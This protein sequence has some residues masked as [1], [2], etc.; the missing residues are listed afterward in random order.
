MTQT[1]EHYPAPPVEEAIPP[2][3]RVLLHLIEERG[4]EADLLFS[5]GNVV[6]RK[7]R[8]VEALRLYRAALLKDA[9]SAKL[10]TNI[11]IVLESLG[12]L[13]EAEQ[14]Y[15]EALIQ[16]A[17]LELALRNLAQ[18][19]ES[20]NDFESA[21]KLVE[22]SQHL[23]SSARVSELAGRAADGIGETDKARRYF[24][25]AASLGS[26]YGLKWLAADDTRQALR[27]LDEE[28]PSSLIEVGRKLHAAYERSPDI[29]VR[30]QRVQELLRLLSEKKLQYSADSYQSVLIV[31]QQ[32]ALLPECFEEREDLKTSES[33]WAKAIDSQKSYPYGNY[34]R[35][36]ILGMLGE[37]EKALS[38][39]DLCQSKLPEKKQRMLRLVPLTDSIR[40][41]ATAFAVRK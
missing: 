1:P 4:E 34:R 29:F 8:A 5:L 16:D 24:E 2:T 7:G 21:L 9:G 40:S 23:V 10:K 31:L 37:Y 17:S 35:G 36:I 28:H 27:E 19:L 12:E 30:E 26:E 33:Y 32:L 20:R 6:F 11:A 39:L 14:F 13:V 3:E 38:E 15:R 18:I 22:R 25:A 41:I